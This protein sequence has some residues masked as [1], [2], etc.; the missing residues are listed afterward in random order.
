MP[1][2]IKITKKSV[3][4]A[5]R[6]LDIDEG[7]RIEFHGRKLF[8]NKSPSGT[9][10]VQV[11]EEFHYLANASQVVKLANEASGGK[12]TAYSY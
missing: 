10:V 12:Y 5:L 11:G 7:L 4:K 8:V 2:G 6:S 1:V 3:E 9:F